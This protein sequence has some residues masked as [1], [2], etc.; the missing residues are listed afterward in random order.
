LGATDQSLSTT[1]AVQ[2]NS[3]IVDS[4]G[5]EALLVRKNGDT[6]D[7]FVV[8]TT[9]QLCRFQTNTNNNLFI[10]NSTNG[11]HLK[12]HDNGSLGGVFREL[13]FTGSKLSF[14]TGFGSAQD[15]LVIDRNGGN[16]DTTIIKIDTISTIIDGTGTEAL[17]VRKNGDTGDVFT[18][19]TTNSLVTVSGKFNASV[20]KSGT[21]SVSGEYMA[22]TTS[23]FTDNATSGSGTATVMAFNAIAAPTLAATNASVTTTDSATLYIGGSPIAGTNQTITNGYSL[24]VD[25]GNV[26]LDGGFSCPSANINA[27]GLTLTET[28]EATS[29]STGS[30]ATLGG[31][32]IAKR[33]WA[34]DLN[35]GS[36]SATMTGSA[37]FRANIDCGLNISGTSSGMSL[38]SHDQGNSG[39]TARD[40]ILSGRDLSFTT[41]DGSFLSAKIDS[42]NATFYKTVDSTSATTGGVVINGG[43]GIAKNIFIG[44]KGTIDETSTE[45]LLVRKE[46]DTGDVFTVDTTNSKVLC[47]VVQS[48]SGNVSVTT[49]G[50]VLTS[51]QSK[52]GFI[53]IGWGNGTRLCFFDWSEG[54]NTNNITSLTTTSSSNDVTLTLNYNNPVMEIV[55]TS[56]TTLTVYWSVVFTGQY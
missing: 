30:I 51:F 19:D 36:S 14:L 50:V 9:N 8:D 25:S 13:T 47:S 15:A 40:L 29:V 42:T 56:N 39:G 31:V 33:L 18:V 48:T 1:N 32:G 45:A 43:V 28:T 11:V 49:G 2:F 4:T 12:G 34:R 21:P 35:V 54:L 27:F 41:N 24:W 38:Q 16:G 53:T 5:T 17:L 22:L 6:G 46:G 26:R 10:E 37:T 3:A 55:A 20:A 7:V 44:G 23:T 52:S